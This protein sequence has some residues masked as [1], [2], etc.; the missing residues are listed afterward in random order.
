MEGLIVGGGIGGLVTAL[1]LHRQGIGVR[2]FESVRDIQP[3]GVGINLLPRAV[4]I[5]AGL[6][7]DAPLRAIGIETKEELFLNRFGQLIVREPRGRE[8]G[9][10]FPQLSINRGQLQLA[11]LQLV[12][13]RIGRDRIV[14]GHHVAGFD[15]AADGRVTAHFIDRRSG[16]KLPDATGDFLIA[17]DGIRS[18]VRA[19]LYPNEGQP[20]WRG[21]IQWRGA[22]ETAP[23]LSGRT[24]IMAGG[25][26]TFIAY[27]MSKPH[28]DR[29]RSLTNWVARIF[30]DPARGLGPEDWTR[31][32]DRSEF[33]PLYEDWKFDFLDVPALI[34]ATTDIFEYPLADRDPVE[35]WTFGNVTLLG[36]AAHPVVPTGS[37]GALQAIL[38]AE[39]LA[40]AF[41]EHG[42]PGTALAAYEA[43]RIAI[44]TRTIHG[45]RHGGTAAAIRLVE[46]RAPNGFDDLDTVIPPDEMAKILHDYRQVAN[47]ER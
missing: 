1:A 45:N 26:Q 47:I 18:S 12:A 33:L 27:P 30:V 3:L 15:E 20:R 39:A 36:D 16:E 28:L 24:H 19:L 32:A 17:A 7:A 31:R 43:A 37:N 5:L 21:G 10:E 46:E 44:A 23:F 8:A 35:R 14:T 11:L 34:R 13:E 40:A 22:C 9:Y 2:V 25:L 29:G 4:Q 42:D 41:A 6:D 38:D